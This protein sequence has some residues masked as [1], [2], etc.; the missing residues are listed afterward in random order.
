MYIQTHYNTC[1]NYYYSGIWHIYCTDRERE[2]LSRVVSYGVFSLHS[3]DQPTTGPSAVWTILGFNETF[4]CV[5][6][7][8]IGYQDQSP[9]EHYIVFIIV[10][11]VILAIYVILNYLVCT[12]QFEVYMYMPSFIS[13]LPI[14]YACMHAHVP[15]CKCRRKSHRYIGVVVFYWILLRICT[16]WMQ[17]TCGIVGWTTGWNGTKL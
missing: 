17:L 12:V 8:S 6:E 10:I 7:R 16:H 15:N 13:F 14:L 9:C 2:K 11:H 5:S 3:L 4:C 1:N